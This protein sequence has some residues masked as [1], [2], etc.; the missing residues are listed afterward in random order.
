MLRA[1]FISI[2]ASSREATN[3]AV[4]EMQCIL[5]STHDLARR[6][7]AFSDMS[8]PIAIF[9]LTAS[10][11]GRLITADIQAHPWIFQ[12][13]TSQGGRLLRLCIFSC[14]LFISTHDLAR[15]STQEIKWLNRRECH[16]NSRPRCGTDAERRIFHFNSRPREEVDELSRDHAVQVGISTHD[17]VRRSKQLPEF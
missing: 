7:T 12:L 16:F 11:G 13:T 9:Q 2:V 5:I 17:L 8:S 1:T 4:E 3:E 14:K 15:R 10:R 6:S